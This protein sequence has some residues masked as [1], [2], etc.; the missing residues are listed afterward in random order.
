VSWQRIGESRR[1]EARPGA[2]P[3]GPKL[4]RCKAPL[5]VGAWFW[6]EGKKPYCPAC[7][8]DPTVFPDADLE[9]RGR[10]LSHIRG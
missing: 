5:L 6:L 7:A 10:T 1:C 2:S 9:A 4:K 3:G 8:L